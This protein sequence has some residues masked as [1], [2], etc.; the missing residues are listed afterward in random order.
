MNIHAIPVEIYIFILR[1]SFP[2]ADEGKA[3]QYLI[4]FHA[5]D[6]KNDTI[7]RQ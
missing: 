1:S 6:L 2:W 7:E 5:S 4:F 3:G